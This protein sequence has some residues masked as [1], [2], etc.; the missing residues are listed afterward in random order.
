MPDFADSSCDYLAENFDRFSSIRRE[1]HRRPELAYEETETSDR[2]ASFLTDIDWTVSRGI[3]G[4]GIVATLAGGAGPTVGLRA[5]MD[6]L[7][8]VEKSGV[9]HSSSN[10]GKMHACGHDGHMTIILALAELLAREKQR[11]GDVHLYFQPAEETGSGAQSML[12]DGALTKF[13]CDQMLGFHNWP[14]LPFGTVSVRHGVQMSA[15]QSL[16][17][18]FLCGG[19]HAAMPDNCPDIFSAMSDFLRQ[20]YSRIRNLKD[21][22]EQV[23]FSFTRVNGGSAINLIP[24]K[25]SLEASFRY[26]SERQFLLVRDIVDEI[27]KQTVTHYGVDIETRWIERFAPLVNDASVTS[28]LVKS[29]PDVPGV[30][31]REAATPSMVADD[32]GYF[33]E[34]VPSCYFWMGTGQTNTNLHADNFDFNDNILKVAPAILHNYVMSRGLQE[35]ANTA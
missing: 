26:S 33:A 35:P 32:F 29:L 15:F 14:T 1:I 8:I 6:A 25:I 18:D 22:S 17:L 34:L 31:Y 2:I 24:T 16:E 7:P 3:G 21:A 27:R 20:S 30:S 5:D 13:P 12:E 11:P 28:S 4:T 23:S 9:A 19:G 10:A